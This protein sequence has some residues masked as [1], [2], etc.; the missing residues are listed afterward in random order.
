M[1]L[2]AQLSKPGATRL[3]RIGKQA[4]GETKQHEAGGQRF[5]VQGQPGLTQHGGMVTLPPQP[6]KAVAGKVGGGG[7]TAHHRPQPAAV[8]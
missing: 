1:V 2:E 8:R 5:R 4:H 6:D 7:P 3:Y